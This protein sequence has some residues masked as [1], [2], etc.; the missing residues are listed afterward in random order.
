MTK[1]ANC[2]KSSKMTKVK[3][4][5]SVYFRE[6]DIRRHRGKPDKCFYIVYRDSEGKLVWEKAGWTSEGYSVALASN[7]RAER[8]RTLRHGEDL[9]K[10]KRK[11]ITFGEAWKE[12]DKW[13]ETNI[14]RP[15]DNRSRYACHI[16]SQFATT[17]LDKISPFDLER[18]KS[19]LLKIGKAPA[20]VKQVLAL[21]RQVYN[22][23]RAWGL[24]KGENPVS[25]VKLPKLNNRRKRFLTHAEAH[26]L[27]IE[28]GKTSPQVRDMALLSL[29]TG[30]RA[31][32]IFNLRWSD[33]DFEHGLIFIADPKSGRSRNAFLTKT[34]KKMFESR[35]GKPEELVFKDKRN[36]K[37]I[38]QISNSFSL[39][40]DNL[41]WNKGITDAR[42]RATF[43]TLR[44]TFA[45]WLAIQGTPILHIKEL[46]GHQ[47]LAMTERYSHLIPDVKQVA[48][49]DLEMAFQAGRKSLSDISQNTLQGR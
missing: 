44:H 22:K 27:L 43:H 8:V 49:N 20:T 15:R 10:R 30:L 5:T 32:E 25:L 48:V 11:T 39:A 21:I 1:R 45:S 14:S 47:S 26:A 42:Q 41:E 6:S 24:Y 29:H 4:A 18:L 7:L 31:G 2:G 36:G 46:M 23:S 3:G 17:P 28:L 16:E 12:Y 33:I 37:R 13:Q 38:K 34:V 9:P 19:D 35:T 40:V